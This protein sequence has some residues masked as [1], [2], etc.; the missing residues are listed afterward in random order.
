MRRLACRS[1]RE[2]VV[3]ARCPALT[4]YSRE[5]PMSHDVPWPEA[6]VSGLERRLGVV[7]P[8]GFRQYLRQDGT[9]VLGAGE[10]V[11]AFGFLS[12]LGERLLGRPLRL[13]EP[14]P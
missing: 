11:R 12:A 14:F 2:A 4:P 13:D 6:D 9:A 1:R 3:T 10:M 5:R 8:P 7:L